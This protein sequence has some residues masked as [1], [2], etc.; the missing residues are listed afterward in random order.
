[1]RRFDSYRGHLTE[2][3]VD[4]YVAAFVARFGRADG[5]SIRLVVTDDRAYD[6]LT[7]DVP[8][9]RRGSVSVF[10]TAPRCDEFMR[11]QPRWKPDR[12]STSMVHE[13]IEAV[14]DAPLPTDLVLRPVNR[15]GPEPADGVP[16]AEAAAVA[17][18]SDPGITEPVAEFA[19]FLRGLSPSARLFA[20]VDDEGVVRATSGC[21]V[22][23]EYTRIFFVN[24]EP[25]WRG[26]GI[27]GAMTVGALRVAARAGARRATLD[28]TDAGASLYRRLGFE[29]AGRM[30]RYF[31]SLP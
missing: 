12:P 5:D 10:E 31:R 1:V 2:T 26:R 25:G 9:A 27:G 19:E 13:D 24:T 16:L 23:G 17:I 30:S 4:L 11:A 22:F 21:E 18:A 7:R 14:P 8:S 28:A 3:A 20:A 6:R 15:V 29:S